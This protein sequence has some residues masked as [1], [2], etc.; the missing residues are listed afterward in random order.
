VL[1]ELPEFS[2]RAEKAA[3][4]LCQTSPPARRTETG[5]TRAAMA[6]LRRE[7]DGMEKPFE[8]CGVGMKEKKRRERAAGAAAAVLDDSR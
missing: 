6:R 4:E 5:M 1:Q 8:G 2:V 3:Y 7:E